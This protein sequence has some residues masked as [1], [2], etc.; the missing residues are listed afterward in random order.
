MEEFDFFCPEIFPP[1]KKKN[2][3]R[4]QKIF[5][6]TQTLLKQTFET[7]NFKI[8]NESKKF[9]YETHGLL[10]FKIANKFHFENSNL[11]KFIPRTLKTH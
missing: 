4:I 2:Y 5:H 6:E 1:Q 3:E 11:F 10:K 7:Q 9:N 8:K